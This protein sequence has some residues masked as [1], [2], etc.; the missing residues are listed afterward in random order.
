MLCKCA[1]SV[2]SAPPVEK[3]KKA[4]SIENFSNIAFNSTMKLTIDSFA[5]CRP[6]R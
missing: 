3:K 6:R 2:V 1:V 5:R 4:D